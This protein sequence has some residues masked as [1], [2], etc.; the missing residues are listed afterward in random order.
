MLALAGVCGCTG[1][2]APPPPGYIQVDIENSPT[3]LDPRYGTDAIS[4]RLNELLFDSLVKLDSHGEFA[5]DLAEDVQRPS[6]TELIFH[7]RRDVRFSDGRPLTAR[8]VKY[9][10]DS[11]LDRRTGSMK[12]G[13]LTQIKSVDVLD[14]YTVRVTTYEAYAPALEMATLAIL[15]SGTLAPG[16]G[17]LDAPAGTGPFRLEK[18]ERDDRVV[19]GRNPYRPA[20]PNLI[21]GIIFKIVPDPTVRALELAEGVCTLAENNIQPELLDYLRAQPNL[22]V[23]LAP[24]TS[25]HYITFNFRDPSL[26]DLRVR[27]AIAYAIDRRA[28]VD[29]LYRGTARIATGMLTPENWAYEGNVLTYPY[30]PERARRLLNEAG[31]PA[32]RAGMR[33]LA[34]VYKSTPEGVRQAEALQAMLKRVGIAVKVRTNEFSTF[35]GDI[36]RGDFDITSMRWIGIR[37]PHHYYMVFDSKMTPPAGL[38]RGYYSNPEMDRLVERANVTLDQ[39]ERRKIYSQVQKLA[40]EDLPYISLWWPDNVVVMNKALAGFMPY[41]NGSLISLSEVTLAPQSNAEPR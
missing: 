31:F 8:D 9:S 3:S 24:G 38:N 33:D 16:P 11:V 37:D 21:A 27:R 41:P 4:E 39:L 14:D 23:V 35:Y 32:D 25:Y 2:E 20:R 34:L 29:A 18:L 1:E 5:P 7:L 22:R 30:D 6:P 26:R 15:P 17:A 40:A 10:Y 12:R 19:F 36:Q 28:M 13:G